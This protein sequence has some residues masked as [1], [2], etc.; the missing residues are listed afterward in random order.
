MRN[1]LAA[2]SLLFTLTSMQ[3]TSRPA[4]L[5]DTPPPA[6]TLPDPLVGADGT[7]VHD[8][9]TWQHR[10][11]PELLQL[12]AREVYGRTPLGRPEGM[13]FK[14]TTM[15]HAALGGAATRKEVTVRFGR[16]PNAP[17]MQLLLYVPNAVIARAER[18]PVFLGL[19]FYGNH[20]VHTDPAI[21]RRRGGFRRRRRTERTTAR[22]RRRADRTRRSGPS[23]RSSP[24]GMRSQRCIAAICVPIAP[25]D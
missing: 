4:R 6:Y 21:A 10:R 13:V 15:E 17:S 14:V 5:D 3:A 16:D 20:T 23:S 25:T 12:F 11:R 7:R 8:R 1:V 2:L 9:A 24:A 19:N 18:A 22:R